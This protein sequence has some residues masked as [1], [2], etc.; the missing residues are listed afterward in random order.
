ML[1]VMDK[2]SNS[3]MITTFGVPCANTSEPE[4]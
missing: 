4:P 1:Y 2:A 3:N